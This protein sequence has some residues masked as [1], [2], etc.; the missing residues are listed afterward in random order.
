[1]ARIYLSR[2]FSQ[3]SWKS[4]VSETSIFL[5]RKCNFCFIL[6]SL[7]RRSFPVIQTE[8]GK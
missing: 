5:E 3:K 2:H 7:I 1:M 8:L 4:G 6:T